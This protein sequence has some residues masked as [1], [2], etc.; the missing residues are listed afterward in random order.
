MLYPTFTAAIDRVGKQLKYL[1][2]SISPDRWQSTDMSNK[3]EAE[4]RELLNVS[5]SVPLLDYTTAKLRKEIKPNLPWADDHFKERVSGRPLNPGEQWKLWPWSN[6]ADKFRTEGDKFSHTYMERYWTPP[7]GGIR[8]QSGNL[9]D[10]IEHLAVHPNSRQAI[11]PI[12]FPEDTGVVHEER[13][14]CSLF[15]QFIHR[16]GYFHHVYM[17]RSCDFYRH[18]RDDVYLSVLLHLWMLKQLRA[19]DAEGDTT[20]EFWQRVHLGLFTF[21]CVSM[22]CFIND[23]RKLFND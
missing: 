11:L 4:M 3:P 6:S 18:F 14:P 7:L 19:R 16:N 5:F 17:I 2:Y 1:S 15:H 20:G 8:Y 10:V 13:V 9:Q 12:W 22:H 21:H 23:F